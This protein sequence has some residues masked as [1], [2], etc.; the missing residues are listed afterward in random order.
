KD[1]TVVSLDGQ[2]GGLRGFLLA[3]GTL[4]TRGAGIKLTALF[5]G[6][7]VQLLDLS[8]L[9]E[10]TRKPELPR[11]AWLVNGGNVRPHSEAIGH[12]GKVPTLNLETAT[13]A[14]QEA[15][16]TRPSMNY[17][18]T[19]IPLAATPAST[20]VPQPPT[21]AS[22]PVPLAAT[23]ASTPVPQPPTPSSTNSAIQPTK[24]LPMSMPTPQNGAS[25]PPASRPHYHAPASGD[26][27][28]EAYLSYQETMRQFLRLQEQVMQQFL[29]GGQQGQISPPPPAVTPTPKRPAYQ[30]SL[31][32]GKHSHGNGNGNGVAKTPGVNTQT[33]VP[34]QTPTTVQ[35][36]Q[37]VPLPE[38][39]VT[40][41]MEP[42]LPPPPTPSPSPLLDRAGLLQT[43]LQL[44]S[45]RTG[46]PTEMLGLNQDLEAEL[47][48]DSIKRVE[49]LGA[50]Q[51]S[52]P[53]PLAGNIQSS[54]ESLT[55]VKSLN[56]MVDQLLSKLQGA[57]PTP[58]QPLQ[59]TAVGATSLA[60]LPDKMSLTQT[61]LHLVSD[62][63]GYPTEMLGLDQD[64][65][66]ELGIDSIKRVEIL[67]ALQ[68]SL[69]EPFASS[70]Q[71]KMESLTRVKSLNG[72]VG[73][74]LEIPRS[75][76]VTQEENSLGKL[77]AGGTLGAT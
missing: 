56:G 21:R 41:V 3:L 70:V 23:P 12:T 48:I 75:A 69:P 51:K 53:Q 44:V 6:R 58:T 10:V 11:T 60:S 30:P 34:L 8:R 49:I 38:I 74:L 20:P 68:K 77:T 15:A 57:A 42:V 4:V 72:I 5:E 43:L 47:G 71:S 46:Y 28:L 67:G 7:D 18:S 52:L 27:A 73:Q 25:R 62:R 33:F 22:T 37:P 31:S 17:A 26:A 35:P 1:H 66:A 24:P 64:L 2:G 61:L 36:P 39:A 50:L 45:D 9:V 16:K 40:Q 14:K 76:S 32:N 54:M 59:A 55:R 19:P 13:Q 63:T 65:E 29:G